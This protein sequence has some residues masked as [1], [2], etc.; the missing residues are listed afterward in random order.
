MK[1]KLASSTIWRSDGWALPFPRLSLHV[2]KYTCIEWYLII[3][4]VR[5]IGV[6]VTGYKKFTYIYTTDS[7]SI[8]YK[9]INHNT[10]N[11]RWDYCDYKCIH[12]FMTTVQ[13]G[14][15]SYE[16]NYHTT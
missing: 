15:K 1:T 4:I 14:L 11:I 13:I 6:Y 7:S 12:I 16:I 3:V 10:K 8:Q 5:D 2:T 9:I